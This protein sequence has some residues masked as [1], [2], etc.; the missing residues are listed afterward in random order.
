KLEYRAGV[1]AFSG[2]VVQHGRSRFS[3]D[4]ELDF[5]NPQGT[6]GR[7]S[8][9]FEDGR[10]SDLVEMVGE[11]HWTFD[12]IRDRMQARISGQ[13]SVDGLLTAPRSLIAISL[14]DVTYFD[15]K[16]GTGEFIFRSQ[17]GEQI[18]I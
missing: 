12:L 16:V 9:T 7:G 6:I 1:L 10:L 8:G 4:G 5:R 3:A 11:E 2:I 14:S 15:R 18:F 13:A 17:D